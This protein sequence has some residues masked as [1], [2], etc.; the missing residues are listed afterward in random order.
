MYRDRVTRVITPV[1]E[2]AVAKV[3]PLAEA[4]LAEAVVAG[5]EAVEMEA[6]QPSLALLARVAEVPGT[7]QGC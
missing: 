5:V 2:A 4:P 7:T 6:V 1:V 3:V